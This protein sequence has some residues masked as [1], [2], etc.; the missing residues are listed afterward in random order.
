MSVAFRAHLHMIRAIAY[1]TI[2][3]D[4]V[5]GDVRRIQEVSDI[6]FHEILGA[7]EANATLV[8]VLEGILLEI[9]GDDQ[10]LLADYQNTLRTRIGDTTM[11][12][13]LMQVTTEELQSA[14]PQTVT[15]DELLVQPISHVWR[16]AALTRLPRRKLERGMFGTDQEAMDCPICLEPI[17]LGAMVIQL[18]CGHWYHPPCV[19]DWLRTSH[20]CPSCRREVELEPHIPV[21]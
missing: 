17:D 21:L 10:R 6:N 8:D 1:N 4:L 5:D 14:P 13:N 12:E 9:D 2:E 19:T 16:D 15:I 3:L 18:V 11:V 20:S 7:E